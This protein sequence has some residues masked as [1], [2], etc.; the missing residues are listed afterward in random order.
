MSK[1]W[2][3]NSLSLLHCLAA[4]L[5][6]H[7]T[8]AANIA[9][10]AATSPASSNNR[11]LNATSDGVATT[12]IDNTSSNANSNTHNVQNN[13][14]AAAASFEQQPPQQQQQQPM[15]QYAHIS[16]L[17]KEVGMHQIKQQIATASKNNGYN[18]LKF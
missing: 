2:K 6:A 13:E 3:I 15:L 16:P 10:T 12:F 11:L 9:S 5:C 7:S 14:V 17:D 18:L 1:Q 4:L 8:H